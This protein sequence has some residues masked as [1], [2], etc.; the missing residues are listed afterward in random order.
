M[1]ATF[2]KTH[3]HARGI[4]DGL[5][6]QPL[7]TRPGPEAGV[8]VR[9]FRILPIAMRP[10]A[11]VIFSPG[12][13]GAAA[14]LRTARKSPRVI[15]RRP[16]TQR[17]EDIATANLVAEEVRRC[18]HYAGIG[19]LFC[20]PVDAGKMKAADAAGLVATGAGNVVEPPLKTC[21]G[22][23]VLQRNAALR[24]VL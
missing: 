13:F 15:R 10:P 19:R 3:P 16:V 21:D 24:C 20:H 9:A 6:G 11:V 8:I 4:A 23:D 1:S 12:E 2:H 5:T 14:Q 7:G 18:R 22:A 17:S